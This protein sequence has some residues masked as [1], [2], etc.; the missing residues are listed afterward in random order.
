MGMGEQVGWTDETCEGNE[1]TSSALLIGNK[2][3]LQ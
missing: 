3:Q 2:A 1:L